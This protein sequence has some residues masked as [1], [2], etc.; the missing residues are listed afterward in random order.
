MTLG[1]AMAISSTGM[2]AERFRMD[3]VSA[4]IANANSMSVGDT[5]A[6]RRQIV[7]LQSTPHGVAVTRVAPD[8][9]PLR[10]EYEPGNPAADAQ[11]YVEY[12]N[13][14][15]VKEMIDMLTATRA[16]EANVAAFNA[17]RGMARAAMGIGQH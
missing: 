7:H 10:R 11:G 4:N 14:E 13:V 1:R 5:P 12:S 17:T 16:Y 6:Y 15:P 9:A 2:H 3:I 8:M